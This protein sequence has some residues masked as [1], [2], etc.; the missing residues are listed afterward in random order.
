MPMLHIAETTD[1]HS[2]FDFAQDPV[3]MAI[4]PHDFWLIFKLTNRM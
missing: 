2:S 1:L 3:E 4:R